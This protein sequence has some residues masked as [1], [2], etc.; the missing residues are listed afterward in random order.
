MASLAKFDG[1]ELPVSANFSCAPRI[2]MKILHQLSPKVRRPRA[3][4]GS[5]HIQL[6]LPRSFPSQFNTLGGLE[7]LSGP[8][9][10]SSGSNQPL[11]AYMK[12]ALILVPFSNP[13]S[14]VLSYEPFYPVFSA[15]EQ[16][17]IVLNLHREC[18]S[19]EDITILNTESSFLPT[20][21]SLHAK[22]PKLKIVL[23]HCTTSEAIETV[24]QCGPNVVGSEV[25]F[26]FLPDTL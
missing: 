25:F 5:N 2:F 4:L 24:K 9:G 8:V 3:L 15:I 23:E 16:C 1:L 21:N 14:G 11:V 6:E 22:F 7:L 18:P 17:S 10:A 19:S 13:A 12:I 26:F 20:L